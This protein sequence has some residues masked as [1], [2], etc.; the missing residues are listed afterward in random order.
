MPTAQTTYNHV[1]SVY[2]VNLV[3]ILISVHVLLM[4]ICRD[5]VP[6]CEVLSAG[7]PGIIG[8]TNM[9]FAPPRPGGYPISMA[10]ANRQGNAIKAAMAANPKVQL[11]VSRY[12]DSTPPNV[13]FSSQSGVAASMAAGSAALVWMAHK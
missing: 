9:Q 6:P 7:V 2:I 3:C 11:T 1:C 5:D 13:G 10:I 8:Y 4:H 12:I